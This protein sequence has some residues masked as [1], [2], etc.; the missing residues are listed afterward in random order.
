MTSSPVAFS[1]LSSR[2]AVEALALLLSLAVV[3][4]PGRISA[5]MMTAALALLCRPGVDVPAAAL[6]LAV[7]ALFAPLA[8]FGELEPLRDT[9]R[10]EPS[11]TN[12]RADRV[13]RAPGVADIDSRS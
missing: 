13:G 7:A 10:G 1:T 5:G 6:V 2:Y 4:W 11:P 8:S 9:R 12:P 3:A